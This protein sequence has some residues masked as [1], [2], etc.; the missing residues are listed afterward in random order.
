LYAEVG[1]VA[2]ALHQ[3]MR[4]AVREVAAAVDEAHA[5]C[6]RY[7]RQ[8]EHGLRTGA[9]KG[10]FLVECQLEV[11]RACLLAAPADGLATE[12]GSYRCPVM[13]IDGPHLRRAQGAVIDDRREEGRGTFE[14]SVDGRESAADDDAIVQRQRV[15][16]AAHVRC[17]G[18]ELA[19]GVLPAAA[20][21][22][23]EGEEQAPRMLP[24]AGDPRD[25]R[26]A[27]RIR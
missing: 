21:R 24:V 15:A 8:T 10:E 20:R 6:A 16:V 14:A 23:G 5:G 7:C 17:R 18:G 27:E 1:G 26:P 19:P 3:I 9:E 25:G 13:E 2:Q 11:D 12:P 22:R 4:H